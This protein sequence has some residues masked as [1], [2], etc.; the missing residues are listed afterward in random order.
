TSSGVPWA[1]VA[2]VVGGLAAAGGCRGGWL[3]FGTG[4]AG[5]SR[6]DRS[7]RATSSGVPWAVVAGVVGGL[8]V[9]G[10]M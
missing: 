5:R 10:G 8:A 7:H 3:R 2:G 4:F 9:S 1:V 6:G